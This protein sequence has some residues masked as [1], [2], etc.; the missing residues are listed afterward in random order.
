VEKLLAERV[1]QRRDEQAER[2]HLGHEQ[3]ER[4][5]VADAIVSDG[6]VLAMVITH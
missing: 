6:L 2:D 1:G 4:Q 5:R 3:H